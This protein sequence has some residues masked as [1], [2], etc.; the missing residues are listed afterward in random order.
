MEIS[1]ANENDLDAIVKVNR[2]FHLDIPDFKW[3]TPEWVSEKIKGWNYYTIKEE[4]NVYGAMCLIPK[5]RS[6][7]IETIAVDEDHQK[8]GIG[9]SLVEFAKDYAKQQGKINITVESFLDYN[10]AGFYE[11]VGF[12]KISE[13]EYRGMQY[14]KFA[15]EV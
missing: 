2:L 6:H 7:L 5:L 4:G 3:D 14:C 12:K 8:E 11:S 1:Q 15:M 9:T 13:G 10:L